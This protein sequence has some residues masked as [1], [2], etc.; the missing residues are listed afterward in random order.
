MTRI[1]ID[2]ELRVGEML[3][4]SERVDRRNHDVVVPVCDQHW[5]PD[6][7]QISVRGT[8]GLLPSRHRRELGSRCLRGGWGVLIR[9][10]CASRC[11]NS[12][13]ADWLVSVVAKKSF[14][15]FS[16]MGIC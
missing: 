7:R 3:A 14:N 8:A 13:P 4:E 15:S 11:T 1:R 6:L 12:R 2:N 10:T 5:L 9:G 16:L